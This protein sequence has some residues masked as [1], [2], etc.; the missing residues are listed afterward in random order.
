MKIDYLK[1]INNFVKST[2]ASGVATEGINKTLKTASE[3]KNMPHTN[4]SA[5][6]N[7]VVTLNKDVRF[8]SI[9]RLEQARL[10]KE[11]LN[12]PN[13][14]EELFSFLLYKKV[15]SE[16][17]ET[18][19]K[20][21]DQK[22]NTDLIKQMLQENSKESLNKL[23]K[24]FQQAPGGTQNT[25]QIKDILALLSQVTPKQNASA[26][27]ILTNLTL[28]YLPWLPLSEKQDI[29]IRFEKRESKEEDDSEQTVLVVY[30][31]TINLGRFRIS[32]IL[33][34]DYSIKIEIN[35]ICEEKNKKADCELRLGNP[36]FRLSIEK[37]GGGGGDESATVMPLLA[38]NQAE[39]LEKILKRIN[40]Q[41]RKDKINASTE[42]FISEEKEKEPSKECKREVIIS[43]AKEVSPVLI[44]MAQ[45]IAKII[46]ETDER[47]SLLQERERMSSE[48]N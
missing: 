16:T 36:L 35:C 48:E 12:L 26:Q 44:I 11:L 22:L 43:T 1:I 10:I 32:I 6:Q 47:I 39:Y 9:N 8:N 33:N 4:V 31:T 21:T 17:L 7:A 38:S 25:D 30:I 23:L 45:K 28:L 18:L 29:E 19:L 42:I 3:A 41:A 13:E 46:L 15:S 27:E 20:Q 37:E 40:E 5:N 34:K 24:L 2:Q 14:I